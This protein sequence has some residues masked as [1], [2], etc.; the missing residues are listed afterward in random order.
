MITAHDAH[1]SFT[2]TIHDVSVQ[3]RT[4]VASYSLVQSGT[5]TI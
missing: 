1:L 5:H 4:L 3:N 2:G